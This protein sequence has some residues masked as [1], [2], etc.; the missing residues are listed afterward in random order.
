MIRKTLPESSVSTRNPFGRDSSLQGHEQ[1]PRRPYTK[2]RNNGVS[3]P[4]P[5]TPTDASSF[6]FSPKGREVLVSGAVPYLG[7]V[8]GSTG[9]GGH[10]LLC[11]SFRQWHERR[12]DRACPRRRPSLSRSESFNASCLHP[13]NHGKGERLGHALKLRCGQ[14]PSRSSPGF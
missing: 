8:R 11:G 2:P 4:E 13:E 6:T 14:F 1:R 7:Q 12:P 5:C 3:L 9:Y 10:R